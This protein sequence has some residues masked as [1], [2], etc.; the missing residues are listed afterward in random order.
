MDK[1]AAKLA[2]LYPDWRNDH[3]TK[4]EAAVEIGIADAED[5]ALA[6]VGELDFGC[7]A[8]IRFQTGETD[9]D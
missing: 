7:D 2:R 4:L 6:E 1:Y 5:L 8:V 9:Y 3:A